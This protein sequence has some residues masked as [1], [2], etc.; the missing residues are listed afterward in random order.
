M[1]ASVGRMTLSWLFLFLAWDRLTGTM[2]AL[3][4]RDLLMVT[5]VRM[6]FLLAHLE[7]PPPVLFLHRYVPS[8]R[9]ANFVGVRTQ[10]RIVLQS[11]VGSPHYVSPEVLREEMYGPPVDLWACGIIMHIILTRRYPF[12]GETIQ[13]TLEL[14][15]KGRFSPV[16]AEWDRISSDAKSLL[17]GL[18]REDPAERL[19]AEEALRHPW[20]TSDLMDSPSGVSVS[21]VSSRTGGRSGATVSSNDRSANG[22]RAAQ[23]RSAT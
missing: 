23:R 7:Q 14:V 9:L 1:T 13:E 5:N 16:G 15:C 8:H 2:G 17:Q 11:Q 3:G 19:T 21:N 20:L 22:G 6:P 12:A 18:L 4:V 10:S